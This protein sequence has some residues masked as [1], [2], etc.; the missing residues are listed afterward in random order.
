MHG[1]VG[2][3]RHHPHIFKKCICRATILDSCNINY[4]DFAP[5]SAAWA[6]TSASVSSVMR[7]TRRLGSSIVS[8]GHSAQKGT[9]ATQCSFS[10]TIRARA[11]SSTRSRR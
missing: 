10:T 5:V 9:R 4:S 2:T 6:A 3:T 8:N 7:A 11:S 1:L